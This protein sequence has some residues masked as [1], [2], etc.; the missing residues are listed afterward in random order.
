VG[1]FTGSSISRA[2]EVSTVTR[3][4]WQERRRLG[5]PGEVADSGTAAVLCDTT[6]RAV[7]V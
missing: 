3:D 2:D 4:G 7:V 5:I 6:R 1:F